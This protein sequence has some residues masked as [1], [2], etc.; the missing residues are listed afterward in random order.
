[1]TL[2]TVGNRSLYERVNGGD[3]VIER[4]A[5]SKAQKAEATAGRSA[6]GF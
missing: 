6:Q 3:I 4:H 1:V 5:R 2:R